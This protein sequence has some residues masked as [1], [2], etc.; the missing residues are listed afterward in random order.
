[1]TGQKYVK[2][3]NRFPVI[4]PVKQAEGVIVRTPAVVVVLDRVDNRLTRPLLKSL[5]SFQKSACKPLSRDVS[6]GARMAR[7]VILIP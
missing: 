4:P 2:P 1:M 3:A 6:G 5:T 7:R